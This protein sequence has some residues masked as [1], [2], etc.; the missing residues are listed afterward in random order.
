MISFLYKYLQYEECLCNTPSLIQSLC[1]IKESHCEEQNRDLTTA[2]VLYNNV[3]CVA[4]FNSNCNLDYNDQ[5]PK[6]LTKM[7]YIIF[8]ALHQKPLKD[9]WQQVLFSPS[10]N[11]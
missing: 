1:N 5:Q 8:Q 10:H 2:H 4:V 6:K 7:C 9:D 3:T 11:L